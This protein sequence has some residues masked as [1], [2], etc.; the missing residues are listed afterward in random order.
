MAGAYAQRDE[1]LRGDGL[2]PAFPP[3]EYADRLERIRK[4]MTQERIDLLYLTAPESLYYVHGYQAY[5]YQ[6]NPPKAWPPVSGTALHA[7]EGRFVHFD[8]SEEKPLVETTSISRDNRYFPSEPLEI[9]LPFLVA[10][11][12]AQGWLPGRVGLELWSYRPNPAVTRALECALR[13]AGCEVVDASDV[14]RDVRRLKSPREVACVEEATRIVDTAIL[15]LSEVLRPGMTELEIYGEMVRSMSRAGGEAP[16]LAQWVSSRP[17]GGDGLARGHQPSSRRAVESGQIVTLDPCGV[18]QRY[19]SNVGRSYFLGD[20]PRALVERYEKAGGAYA[21]LRET[22]KAGTP[23]ADVMR[24]LRAYYREAGIWESEQWAGGYELGISF[25][26]D[27]VGNFLFN[28]QDEEHPADFEAGMVTNYES[29]FGTTLID[30]VVY[31]EGGA[32][33]LSRIP[34]ELLII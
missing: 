31:E 29:L 3:E 18:Y 10:E 34:P 14:L 1:V 22:A 24:A 4:R 12:R 9:A 32:R 25:P 30:T 20:P 13:D 26:P 19:H 27:W 33:T 2:A 15:S 8:Q 6:A 17:A 5:W 7:D 28:V 11:L 21:V 16:G 23:V